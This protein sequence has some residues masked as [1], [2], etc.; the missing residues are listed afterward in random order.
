MNENKFHQRLW[1]AWIM[2]IFFFP[3]GLFLL[4]KYKHHSLKA[5]LAITGILLAIILFNG[6]FGDKKGATPAK[7]PQATP[8]AATASAPAVSAPLPKDISGLSAYLQNYVPANIDKNKVHITMDESS[9]LPG[10]YLVE[11]QIDAIDL[12]RDKG[13]A[14]ARDFVSATYKAT[15][16]A[17]LPVIYSSV[18][19]QKP[20]GS[21]LLGVGLGKLIAD[22]SP[23]NTWSEF[24]MSPSDFES[25][26][27]K[28]YAQ[29]IKNGKTFFDGRC[30]INNN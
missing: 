17:N 24:K 2:I 6:V 20:D 11:L 28:N 22:K 3:V 1:F 25:F 4:W 16:A 21:R 9:N 14:I 7:Q 12:T 15:Y 29:N 23:Q 26:M 19:I 13:M 18:S 8:S 27:K 5:R 10:K 30:F